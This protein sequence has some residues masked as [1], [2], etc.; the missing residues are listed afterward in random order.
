[1]QL[2]I[3]ILPT[4]EIANKVIVIRK[5]HQVGRISEPHITIVPP[6]TPVGKLK[7]LE[8]EIAEIAK[9][10][11]P[12]NVKLNGLDT[13]RKGNESVLFIK[14]VSQGIMAEIQR[15]VSETLTDR[16]RGVKKNFTQDFHLTVL[17]RMPYEDLEKIKAG[18]KG[19]EL[20]DEF[21]TNELVLFGIEKDEAWQVIKKFKFENE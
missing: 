13:Y 2:Y 11:K 10:F 12:F 14:I 9:L 15:R 7:E 3:A 1:M 19:T 18:L 6:F 16:V 17:K 21:V 8:A 4:E 20:K 5:K